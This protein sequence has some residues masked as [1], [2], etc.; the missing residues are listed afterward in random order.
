MSRRSSHHRSLA[1]S[2]IVRVL[3]IGIN[4]DMPFLVMGYAPNGTLRQRYPSRTIP[5]PT[6]ILPSGQKGARAYNFRGSAYLAL[7]QYTQAIDDFDQVIA[8]K[9][10]Y[11][12]AYRNRSLAYSVLEMCSLSTSSAGTSAR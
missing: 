4:D 7:K 10:D 11:S 1:A 12:V 9:P 2:H 5:T 3:D 6:S 8:L